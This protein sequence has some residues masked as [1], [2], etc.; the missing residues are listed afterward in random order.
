MKAW[1]ELRASIIGILLP[2][3]A[4]LVGQRTQSVPAQPRTAGDFV[5]TN[6]RVFDGRGVLPRASVV[7]RG[8]TI[9]AVGFEISRPDGIPQVDA[10]GATLLPGFIDAHVHV[11]DADDLRQALRFGATT[12]LD[13]GALV[14]P[15]ALF[16]LRS[17][18]AEVSDMADLRLAG[19]YANA[20]RGD[21]PPDP[22][23]RVEIP[24]VASVEA[25][26]EFVAA[27]RT[28][29]ADYVKIVLHGS[30]GAQ[31]GV[32]NIDAPRVKALIEAAHKRVARGR[33]CRNPRRRENRDRCKD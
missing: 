9:S 26:R 13:M 7:V 24:P 17:A 25:A 8:G 18:A 4:T 32:P 2:L 16:S 1:L 33:A 10:A 12:V 15:K 22:R 19:F 31:T 28:E 23:S 3:A 21:A 29:G 11:P 27:R 14:E 6:A 5:I 20:P 30:R